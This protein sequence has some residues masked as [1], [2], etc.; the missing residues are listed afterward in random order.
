MINFNNL[1]YLSNLFGGLM[2]LWF[3][4]NISSLDS[5]KDMTLEIDVDIIRQFRYPKA[6]KNASR[7]NSKV[8]TVGVVLKSCGSM[9]IGCRSRRILGENLQAS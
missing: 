7:V 2:S 8:K 9:K 1:S 5:K 4:L 6:L 3:S